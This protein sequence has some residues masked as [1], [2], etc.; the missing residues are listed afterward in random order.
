[1]SELMFSSQLAVAS[2]NLRKGIPI[3]IGVFGGDH[4]GLSLCFVAFAF[5]IQ[6]RGR[7]K[8]IENGT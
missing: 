4:D 8:K 1:M 6:A 3:K 7:P 5:S 2:L